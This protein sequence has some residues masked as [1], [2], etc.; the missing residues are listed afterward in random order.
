LF[1]SN[2]A[3]RS[4]ELGNNKK[5]INQKSRKNQTLSAVIR[6]KKKKSNGVEALFVSF[7]NPVLLF[8]LSKEF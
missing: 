4:N 3:K 7:A 8:K 1:A 6:K 2:Q 5:E